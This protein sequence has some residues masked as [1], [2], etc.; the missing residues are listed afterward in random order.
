MG[1]ETSALLAADGRRLLIGGAGVR[2]LDTSTLEVSATALDSWTVTGLAMSGDGK[3]IYALSDS[4]QVAAIDSAAHVAGTFD[5]GVAHA[6]GLL[7]VQR[8]S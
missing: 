6:T 7:S 1:G 8:F 5:S 3:R 4:G 2:W